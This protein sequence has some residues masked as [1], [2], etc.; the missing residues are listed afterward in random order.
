M[1][2]TLRFC[3]KP[4]LLDKGCLETLSE[5]VGLVIGIPIS[6]MLGQITRNLSDVENRLKPEEE[7]V[8]ELVAS[9]SRLDSL[10]ILLLW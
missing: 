4:A 3:K 10:F 5:T 7:F 9:I 2:C 1:D 6:P 8:A